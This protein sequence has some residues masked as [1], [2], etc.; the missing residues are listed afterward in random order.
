LFIIEPITIWT[1]MPT[2]PPPF[3]LDILRTFAAIVDCG[4]FTRAAERVGAPSPL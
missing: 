2:P 1:P 4:G 3:D